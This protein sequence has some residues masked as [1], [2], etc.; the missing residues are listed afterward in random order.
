[1]WDKFKEQFNL[2]KLE[3]KK[4]CL[5]TNS[6]KFISNELFLD[7]IASAIQGGVDIVQLKETTFPDYVMAEIAKKVR[8]ICDEFGATFVVNSRCDIA[9]IAEADGVH[10]EG[11]SVNISDAR[12][13]MGEHSVIGIT[14]Y[15]TED[16]IK[17]YNEGVDYINFAPEFNKKKNE[18]VN[19]DDIRW[20][21][22]NIDIPIFITGEINLD[23]IDMVVKTGASKIA[24]TNALMYAQIPEETAQEFINI[25]Q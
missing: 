9:Q 17:A 4:L 10:L 22:D 23:N 24:L 8:V 7:A 1:M 2:L 13:I 21:N 14:A 20:L 5:I 3:K 15:T 6:D 25:L 18:I 11:D 19:A 16:V 12:T